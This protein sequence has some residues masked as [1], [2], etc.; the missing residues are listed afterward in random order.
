ME[1]RVNDLI[2]IV[3]GNDTMEDLLTDWG[4]DLVKSWH[5]FWCINYLDYSVR[6][7]LPTNTLQILTVHQNLHKIEKRQT[8]HLNY[9]NMALMC[10]RHVIQLYQYLIWLHLVSGKSFEA[11]FHQ[12]KS[13][14]LGEE[15]AGNQEAEQHFQVHPRYH[16]CAACCSNC[17]VLRLISFRLEAW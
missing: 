10:I 16:G 5:G 1:E 14:E 9:K 6:M 12:T 4:Q 8:S 11:D 2:F 17:S 13:S 3:Q 7:H 15:E